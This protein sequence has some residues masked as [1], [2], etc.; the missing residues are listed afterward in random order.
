ML[1]VLELAAQLNRPKLLVRTAKAAAGKYRRDTHL[2]RVLPGKKV[3]RHSEAIFNLIE[4]ERDFE[5]RRRAKGA[6][7]ALSDHL[8]VLIAL[9]AEVRLL[10]EARQSRS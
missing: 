7:Y 9:I 5:D 4:L 10:S 3:S 6:G 8:D 1:D 2:P